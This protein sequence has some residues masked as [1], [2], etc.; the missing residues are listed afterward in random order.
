MKNGYMRIAIV[1]VM[2]F[3][4]GT[5]VLL[6]GK[7][8]TELKSDRAKAR[9]YYVEG[10]VALAEGRPSEAYEL[11]K[12]AALIDPAY[13]E[14][15]YA[16]AL[17]RMSLRNDTLVSPTEVARSIAMMRPYVD[18][19][20]EETEE[21][22][23]YSFLAARSGDLDEAIRV[24]ERCDSLASN[25]SPIL[26][27]LA[28]Y[29]AAKQDLD[30]ALSTLDRYERIEGSD[31]D[32]ALRKF[33]LM[34]SKGDTL[35]L[36]NESQRLVRE[37]PV[38]PDYLILRG[39]VYEAIEM[40]D[41][42]LLCY[43]QAETLDPDDGRVK[44][45]LANYWLERGDSAAYD[46]KSSEAILSDNIMLDEKLEMMRRYMENIINDSTA[47]ARRGARLFDGLLRQYPHEPSVLDLGAQYSAAVNNLSR[48]EEL[49]AY[50]TD[51]E[52]DNQTYWTRLAS[53]YFTD[54][55][56]ADAIAAVEKGLAKLDE[57]SA[58][59]LYVYG[60]AA[61][62][63]KQYEKA[64]EA[65]QG[66]LDLQLPGALLDDT[67]DVMLEKAG[68]LPYESLARVADIFQMSGDVSY[69]SGDMQ[70]ATREYEVSATLDPTDMMTLNNYAYYLAL[71]GGDLDKAEDLSR[72]TVAEQPENPTYLDTLAWILYLKGEY[73]EALEVQEKAIQAVAGDKE[74][75]GEFWDHL[76]DIQYRCGLRDKAL[77]SWRK[78]LELDKD[79]KEIA[80]KIRLKK[81]AE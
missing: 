28:Q 62:M 6:A 80:K 66:L 1:T 20:P 59:L 17:M 58:G 23:N 45:T 33:A 64:R 79:N 10:S 41:S 50:A 75:I 76:G 43:Q 38:D 74:M 61:L 35:A 32:L 26:L 67:A 4:T 71:G 52:P 34:F 51:L 11:L 39:N 22:M 78:A 55:K 68:R 9:Y 40:P 48:A 70:R 60:A 36:L 18:E 29:Y 56:Y 2:A 63:D 72:R 3:L 7:S 12:K 54:D 57:P 77:E 13:S 30:R 27:Q 16:Y 73:A 47:D 69:Q 5:M 42:A 14:A 19:H 25:V 81:I 21:A 46:L 24:A 49:M 31:P 53:F 65:Y 8:G 44:L 37:N 15:A